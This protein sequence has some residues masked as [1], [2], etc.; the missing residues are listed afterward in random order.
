MGDDISKDDG[1]KAGG[2]LFAIGGIVYKITE[3]YIRDFINAIVKSMTKQIQ[4]SKDGTITIPNLYQPDF[5]L[6]VD[7]VVSLLEEQNFKVATSKLQMKDA[8]AK[9][10]DCINNQV[11]GT[12]PRH[13]KKVEVGS[14][15]TVR[16]ISQDVIDASQKMFNDK[17]KNK[18]EKKEIKNI[19]KQEHKEQ[20]KEKFSYIVNKTKT[21]A[22]GILKKERNKDEQK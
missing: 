12:N 20:R 1:L 19:Q 21:M 4:K 14:I 17:E 7:I 16:Y 9:Y 11:V 13:G 2:V 3:P 5:P 18:S 10:K 6:D 22:N 15:I 8:N